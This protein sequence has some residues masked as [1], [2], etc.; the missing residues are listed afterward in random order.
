MLRIE[1][2]ILHLFFTD[3]KPDKEVKVLLKKVKK[4]SFEQ[5]K[6]GKKNISDL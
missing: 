1:V 5:K 6:F 2:A 3:L 4:I